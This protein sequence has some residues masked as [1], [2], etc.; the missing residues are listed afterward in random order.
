MSKRLDE[1]FSPE[2]LQQ[3]WQRG[4][5][6][7]VS[8]RAAEVPEKIM[9]VADGLEQ[10]RQIIREQYPENGNKALNYLADQLEE[11][12]KLRFSEGKS[13]SEEEVKSL[14]IAAE[15]ILCQIEDLA[16]ALDM[17]KKEKLR[18]RGY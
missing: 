13:V 11:L 8:D 4:S 5:D 3:R 7:T 15:Q 12:L 2:R 16:E 10:L 17:G 14:N 18:E 6:T 9:S 1:L